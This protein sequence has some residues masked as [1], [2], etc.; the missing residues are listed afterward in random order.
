VLSLQDAN[1]F[2]AVNAIA[3]GFSILE[4]TVWVTGVPNEGNT[5]NDVLQTGG[6]TVRNG[7][8]RF[9]NYL[10]DITIRNQFNDARMRNLVYNGTLQFSSDP[11]LKEDVSGANLALCYE[12]LD[13][14]PLRT[15]SYIQPYQ[16]TFCQ[17]D[18]TPRIGF[19]TSEVAPYFPKSVTTTPFEYSW[20]PSTIQ[21][22]DT[23]QVK[24]LH[25]GATQHLAQQVSTLETTAAL[26]EET[27]STLRAVATQRTASHS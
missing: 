11:A 14:L 6:I 9:P 26:L 4:G 18:S 27:C 5:T 24:F 21:M 7:N 10:A 1:T 19:L 13:S 15:Y 23:T 16:S 8:I 17:Y 3:G 22:L 12:T 25:L 2:V 20:G